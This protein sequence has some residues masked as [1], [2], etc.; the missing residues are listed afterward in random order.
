M[1]GGGWC[2]GCSS[3]F[4]SFHLGIFLFVSFCFCVNKETKIDW[5]EAP[6]FMVVT[7]LQFLKSSSVCVCVCVFGTHC[8]NKQRPNH[9]SFRPI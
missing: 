2:G 3:L 5:I 8:V 6:I 1:V 9:Q 7:R 4:I